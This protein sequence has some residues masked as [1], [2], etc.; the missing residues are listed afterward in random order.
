MVVEIESTKYKP[1]D[2]NSDFFCILW[3]VFQWEFLNW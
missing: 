2:I 3:I 1:S